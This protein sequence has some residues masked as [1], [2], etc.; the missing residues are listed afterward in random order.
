MYIYI[1]ILIYTCIYKYTYIY[2]CIYSN[3]RAA[4]QLAAAPAAAER[5][6]P[7]EPALLQSAPSQPHSSWG[8]PSSTSA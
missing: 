1:Y 2:V 7:I 3:Y 6:R 5:P 4:S 8:T